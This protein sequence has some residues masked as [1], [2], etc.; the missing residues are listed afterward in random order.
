MLFYI[1]SPP[2]QGTI[3]DLVIHVTRRR[4]GWWGRRGGGGGEGDWTI[5][6][7]VYYVRTC[8]RHCA[9]AVGCISVT[10]GTKGS[11]MCVSR[12]RSRGQA[13]PLGLARFHLTGEFR[14]YVLAICW[15]GRSLL[16]S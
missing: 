10:A 3:L 16:A 7:L 5:F 11:R 1:Q 15:A 6:D 2:K 14:G 4:R 12:S 8:T 9:T 13:A